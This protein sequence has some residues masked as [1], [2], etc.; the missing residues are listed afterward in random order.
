MEKDELVKAIA[1]K[2]KLEPAAVETII[3]ET[4]AEL[5]S[6]YLFPVPGG[7]VGFINDNH[8]TNNCKEKV[9]ISPI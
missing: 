9:A 2:R 8:C 7:K 6:P 5:A 4:I 3:N 1:R